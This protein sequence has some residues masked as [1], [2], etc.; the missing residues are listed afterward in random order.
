MAIHHSLWTSGIIAVNPSDDRHILSTC[1]LSPLGGI[2]LTSSDHIEGLEAFSGSFMLCFHTELQY[3]FGALTPFL[4]VGTDHFTDTF[5][6][7]STF[8]LSV[9]ILAQNL[10]FHSDF[11]LD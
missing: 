9:S 4:K 7:F 6:G 5:F 2:R 1:H 8:V 10:C 11:G 3:F